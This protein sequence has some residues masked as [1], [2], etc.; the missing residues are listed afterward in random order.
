MG[1]TGHARDDFLVARDGREGGALRCF[2]LTL[3]GA[4]W[5]RWGREYGRGAAGSGWSAGGS[6]LCGR[7]AVTCMGG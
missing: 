6:D 2:G 5:L 1:E 3:G 4:C 7:A